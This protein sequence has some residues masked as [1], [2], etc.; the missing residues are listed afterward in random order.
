MR[1]A[2]AVDRRSLKLR[3]TEAGAQMLERSVPIVQGVY[4]QTWSAIGV[5]ATHEMQTRL[6]AVHDRLQ[7]M[8]EAAAAK[9]APFN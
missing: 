8:D 7:A 3:L 5:P 6:R 2:D 9:S 1:S 4:Q